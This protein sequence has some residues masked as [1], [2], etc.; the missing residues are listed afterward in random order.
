MDL[1]TGLL[2]EDP[3]HRLGS[4]SPTKWA[5]VKAHEWF[6]PIDW[7]VAAARELTPPFVPNVS[8]ANCDP[9]WELEEQIMKPT[10]STPP[11]SAE[12]QALFAG[13]EWRVKEEGTEGEGGEGGREEGGGAGEGGLRE[14]QVEV[15]VKE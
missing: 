8:V 7:A 12:E 11:L 14:E 9:V 5:E 2:Q 4:R 13:W 10:V 6:A 15:E 1:L 3:A